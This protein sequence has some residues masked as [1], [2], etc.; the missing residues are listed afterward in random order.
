[1]P[2]LKRVLISLLFIAILALPSLNAMAALPF[3][4][5]KVIVSDCEVENGGLVPGSSVKVSYLL[6]NTSFDRSVYGV[7]AT[8]QWKTMSP[9]ADFATTNQVYIPEIK[10][11]EI[12]PAD[13]QILTR[14]V[15]IAAA[16]GVPCEISLSYSV[17]NTPIT[18][19]PLDGALFEPV[20]NSVTV[21]I[22]VLAKDIRDSAGENLPPV[23]PGDSAK[24]PLGPVDM[25]YVYGAMAVLCL[26][27]AAVI[28]R[29]KRK[30]N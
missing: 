4:N 5:A 7:L 10:P 11:Q 30:T 27:L 29:R 3:A 28:L 19:A 15:D 25:V 24:S 2:V 12:V 1:M 9:P 16:K 26:I 6:Q 20:T 17:P 14:A 22:P 18:G 13:L 21:M 23:L 8:V